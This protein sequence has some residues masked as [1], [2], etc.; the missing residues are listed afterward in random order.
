MNPLGHKQSR[1]LVISPVKDESEYLDKTISSM[2]AQEHRP[3]L[4]VIVNDGSTDTTG[5]I[6]DAAAR[7]HPWIR[8]IHRPRGTQR[9]VGPGVIEAFYAG[10]EAVDL[11]DYDYLC[12]LDGD[13]EFAPDYFA[14]LLQRFAAD[15]RL[16]TASGKANI[17]L[18]GRFVRERTGDEFSHGVAKLY[19][20]E[21]FEAIGGFVRAVMWDGID[22]HR[23]RILGWKAVSYEDPK[24]TILHL[25]PMGSSYRSIYHG[26]LR[27]G[28]GQYFMGT[29]P[30]YL[31]GLSVYRMFE[32]PWVLGG[33]CILAGYLGAWI[34]RQPRYNDLEF[35]RFLH[36]WQFRELAWRLVGG[37]AI[38]HRTRRHQSRRLPSATLDIKRR[39]EAS[40]RCESG[41][42]C[43]SFE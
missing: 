42:G 30:V 16:G 32:R 12:K 33:L 20:R 43:G 22:C 37:R 15:P 2:V 24:L 19:R 8:V 27:W 10:L 40:G 1:L 34:G 39:S 36:C 17:P 28:R 31:V 14:E 13:L 26:R 41:I 23:C 9:R 7:E 38:F 6:A 25:R 35:R 11:R 3:D 29:H 21:C 5:A 18:G 4:W